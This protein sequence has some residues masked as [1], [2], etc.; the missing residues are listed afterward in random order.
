SRG[1]QVLL[2]DPR[3]TA[4]A[5]GRP[6]SDVLDCPWIRRL[7]SYGLLTGAF[8]PADAIVRW[9]G[10]QRQRD[11]LIRYPAPHGQ[12]LQQELEAMGVR[13]TGVV[14]DSG[15]QT[16]M[17]IL[18]DMVRGVRDPVQLAKHRHERCKATEEQIAAAL[19]GN[20]RPE[21]LFALRQALKLYDFYQE[22]LHECE[23]RIEECLRAME[24][25]SKGAPLPPPPRKRK[26]QKNEVRFGARG[27]R[28][29]VG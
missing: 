12:H 16:G 24:D 2:V 29:S 4:H 28:K 6:K 17:K 7:H 23:G 15:G 20:W 18:R 5:P 14:S 8:R 27:D 22:Q 3:Q 9:R 13:V 10:F 19:C 11:M 25:K 21:L 1:F 26:S